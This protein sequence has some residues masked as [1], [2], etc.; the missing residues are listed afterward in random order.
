MT[1]SMYSGVSGL[2]NMQTAIDVI[3]NNIANVNTVGYKANSTN[4]QDIL[5]QTIQGASSPQGNMGGTNP[6]QVGL[7]M[8]VATIGTNF[9]DGN[10]QSTGKSGDLAISGGGFFIISDGNN[11]LYTRAGG[12]TIDSKGNYVA[13]GGYKLMGWSGVDADGNVNTSGDV[14]P[15]QLPLGS[16]M[17]ASASTSVTAANNLQADAAV[18]TSTSTKSTIVDTLG[19]QHDLTTTF[20]KVD[21]NKWL[22]YVSTSDPTVGGALPTGAWQE[23]DFSPEGVYTGTKQIN[24]NSATTTTPIAIPNLKLDS[25]ASSKHTQNYVAIVNGKPHTYQLAVTA[26]AT[27]PN[28]WSYTLNEPGVSGTTPVTGTITCLPA[29]AGYTITPALTIG[30][31]AIT[32]TP[33]AGGETAPASAAFTAAGSLTTA[34]GYTTT[35]SVPFSTS[36]VGGANAVSVTLDYSKLTQ[37]GAT[38]STVQATG[39]GYTAGS[40]KTESLD[41]TGTIVGV[42]SNGQR[43]NLAQVALAAFNNPE[44]LTHEGS[45]NYSISNNSGQP[46]IGTAKSGSRGALS[47]GNLEMSNVDLAKEFSDMIVTERGYQANSKII[48]TSDEMLQ[49]LNNLKR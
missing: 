34:P 28:K 21:D 9:T 42:Y 35:T 10:L 45:T 20:Y 37:Y 29:F 8:S 4:F 27:T 44:G 5:S 1:R 11:Q 2:K 12:F 40:L 26:D 16:T 19:V 47:G 25:D 33:T 18:G 13:P 41:A 48:T 22:S 39:D 14:K 24:I 3:G 23:I 43:R 36:F 17:A 32:L 38:T 15:I 6:M 30:T 31:P 7:G 49:D 46:Q